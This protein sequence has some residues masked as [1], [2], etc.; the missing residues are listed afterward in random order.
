MGE[1]GRARARDA[2]ISESRF[3]ASGMGFEV[4]PTHNDEAVMN[5]APKFVSGPPAT[6]PHLRIEIWG[7]RQS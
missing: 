4:D 3:A 5:G 7:T 6:G 2:P 1:S